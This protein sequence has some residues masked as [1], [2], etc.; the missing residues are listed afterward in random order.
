M[1][2]RSQTTGIPRRRRRRAADADGAAAHGNT[3][4]GES[5]TSYKSR[6]EREAELQRWAIRG[7]IAVALALALLVAAAFAMEQFIIPSQ[8][9]ASVNGE[10]ITVREFRQQYLLERNRLLLQLNQIQNSGFDM[11][12]LSQQEPYRTWISEVNVPDQLGL[13]VINDM[14]DDKL[15]AQE[16]AARNITV[17]DDALTRAVE[18][19]FG[20]DPTEV[21]LIGVEPTS[22]T[23]PTATRTPF[24]SPTPSNTPLPSPTPAATQEVVDESQDSTEPTVTPQPTVV[25]PT[26]SAEEVREDFVQT[27]QDYRGYFDRVGVASETVDGFF[28]RSALEAEF[29]KALVPDDSAVLFADVR[30][31]LVEDEAAALSALIALQQG[32]S[33]AALAR[34]ISTDPGSGFRGGELGTALVAN[35]VPEFSAAI[36]SADIGE[37][38]GPVESEFGFHILQ[39]R[40]KEER[41][42]PELDFQR[43]QAQQQE[44]AQLRETLR[45]QQSDSIEVYDTWLNYIPRS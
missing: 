36:K 32:E 37:L 41:A 20:Y 9:V 28:Q 19:F 4:P 24:V 39:V 23:Q 3:P 43:Q 21:A 22:T 29:A 45:E 42:G 34:A 18:R 14:V 38:V 1:S 40:S 13:R 31:I 16:A 17:D 2:K 26:Q 11:Q 15:L 44:L 35:Y 27:Q 6:S 7:V 8:S 10:A 30:H 33:F 5:E 25:E 12:Q